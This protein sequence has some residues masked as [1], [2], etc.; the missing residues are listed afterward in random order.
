M[1][2]YWFG[3]VGSSQAAKT[4]ETRLW[5]CFP[6][7]AKKGDYIFMYCPRSMSPLRQ[8]IFALCSLKNG[9]DLNHKNNISCAGFGKR[10]GVGSLLYGDLKLIKRFENHLTAKEM[11]NDSI[12]NRTSFVRRNF[13]GTTFKIDD[14]ASNQINSLLKEKNSEQG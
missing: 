14:S 9:L 4:F 8:G 12:L 6:I 2:N 5:W 13:Q 1:G 10:D 3:V 11:K 7:T